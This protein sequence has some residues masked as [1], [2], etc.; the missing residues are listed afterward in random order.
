VVREGVGAGGE[1]NQALYTHM[2]NKRKMK[3]KRNIDENKSKQTEMASLHSFNF[4]CNL[5]YVGPLGCFPFYLSI[6]IT[7]YH[8]MLIIEIFIEHFNF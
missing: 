8:T 6:F 7:Q 3:K 5:D 4:R 2:N 1:M